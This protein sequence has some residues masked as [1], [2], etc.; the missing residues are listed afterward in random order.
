YDPRRFPDAARKRRNLV[1][2]LMV[3][4]GVIS[5]KQEKAARRE[6]LKLAP[7]EESSSSP[8]VEAWARRE[9]RDRFGPDAEV[10]GLRVQTTI[11]PKLQAAADAELRRQIEA[12]E[13]GKMGRFR[14]TKCTTADAAEPDKC[15][16]G[17]VVAVQ[18]MSGDVLALVGGRDHAL[19]QF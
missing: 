18:P 8:W 16:Q 5:D 10:R 7:P 17:L 1:L 12:V 6:K 2:K 14:G 13:A 15:L 11:D 19:S 9:L 4:G 3:E